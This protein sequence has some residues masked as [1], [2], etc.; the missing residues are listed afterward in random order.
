MNTVS[1]LNKIHDQGLNALCTL[2]VCVGRV[3]PT[4]LLRES[5]GATLVFSVAQAERDLRG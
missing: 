4:N 3:T 2:C 5:T 1:W